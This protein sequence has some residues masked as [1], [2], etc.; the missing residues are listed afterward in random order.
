M[1]TV[2]GAGSIGCYVGG[3]LAL[4]GEHVT[5]VGRPGLSD[6]LAQ[7]FHVEARGAARRAVPQDMFTVVTDLKDAPPSETVL[8][9]V[10]SGDTELA[11][12]TIAQ[13]ASQ[14]AS[15]ISLQNGVTNPAILSAHLDPGRV[16]P[17][18]VGFNVVE[19]EPGSYVQTTEGEVIVG[20]GG[21]SLVDRLVQTGVKA[22]IHGNMAGVQWSKLLMNLNNSINT[23]SG[24]GLKAQLE[25]EGW[26]RVLA[27]CMAEGIT[28]ARA[29]GIRLEK[30]GKVHPKLIPHLLRLPNVLF[31]RIA[32]AMLAID[33]TALSSMAEDY[34]KGRKSEVDFLNGYVVTRADHHGL[35]AP[36][37]TRVSTLVSDA[38]AD[39]KRPRLTL[40]AQDV[41]G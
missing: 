7:G 15:V 16:V 4:T 39:P 30:I 31:T 25:D 17:G 33:P 35:A 29:D 38:F 1:I 2:F 11:A 19:L 32:G 34:E 3:M 12:R 21:V 9:C 18:M 10:K 13:D 26:R 8:V 14:G 5:L 37:N 40:T 27:Q 24:I 28:V 23:I 6:K 22:Q 20:Q 41:L 36:V